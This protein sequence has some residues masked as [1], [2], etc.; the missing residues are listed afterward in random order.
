[1]KSPLSGVKSPLRVDKHSPVARRKRI[2]SEGSCIQKAVYGIRSL[3]MEALFFAQR[4][5][6]TLS[7]PMIPLA[8]IKINTHKVPKDGE[9]PYSEWDPSR[10]IHNLHRKFCDPLLLARHAM[11][12]F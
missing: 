2:S 8:D 5:G 10:I 11:A 7:S 4:A 1:M 3:S 6:A 9:E 12:L